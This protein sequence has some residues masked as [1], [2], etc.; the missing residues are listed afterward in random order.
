MR[1][2]SLTQRSHSNKEA[3]L[4]SRIKDAAKMTRFGV[5]VFWG[6]RRGLQGYSPCLGC[7]SRS[8]ERPAPPRGHRHGWAL[9]WW[10]QWERGIAGLCRQGTGKNSPGLGTGKSAQ[11]YRFGRSSCAGGLRSA[12][13]D[14]KH[15]DYYSLS[16]GK[17]H[18]PIS[19]V[20]GCYLQLLSG[21]SKHQT[22][23]LSPTMTD[24]AEG[25]AR[26]ASFTAV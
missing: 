7:S 1:P 12:Q 24:R 2:I 16:P 19:S 10:E 25:I 11:Q 14:G 6:E 18:R 13:G 17:R 15:R 22:S 5:W 8:G 3:I 4:I 21:A 9:S 23:F 20:R 26:C